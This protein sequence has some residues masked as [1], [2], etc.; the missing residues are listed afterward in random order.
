MDPPLRGSTSMRHNACTIREPIEPQEAS[1]I[2]FITIYSLC[3]T[4]SPDE[5]V[6]YPLAADNYLTPNPLECPHY[7]TA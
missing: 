3:Y 6:V 1:P 5:R 4:V 7:T 2:E